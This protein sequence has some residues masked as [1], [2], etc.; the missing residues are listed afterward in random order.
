VTVKLNAVPLIA[1]AGAD[2]VKCVAAVAFTVIVPDVPVIAAVTVSV[3]VIVRGPLVLRVTENVPTP[4]VNVEFAG[5][6]AA[7]SLLVKCTVPVYPVAVLFDPSRA[8]TVKLNA[9]P[10]VAVPGA[11]T[12][13]CVAVP[14]LAIVITPDVPVIEA[15]T[16]SVAVIDCEP[17]VFSVAEKV[18]TP[19]VSVEFAGKVAAP[20]LLVKCTIPAYAVAILLN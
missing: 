9:S 20:S 19:F 12:A 2:T 14:A 7:P 18:P 4:L 6:V 13:K 16:V 17:F 15:V 10:A 8:V 1:V 3:A 5:N 11:E